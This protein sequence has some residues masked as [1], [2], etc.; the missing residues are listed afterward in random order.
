LY[1][2][3]AKKEEAEIRTEMN[4]RKDDRSLSSLLQEFLGVSAEA[5]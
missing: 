1:V 5:E 4:K 2:H 3:A